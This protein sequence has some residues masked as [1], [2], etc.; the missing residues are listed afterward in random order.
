MNGNITGIGAL[1]ICQRATVTGFTLTTGKTNTY[2]VSRSLDVA[3]F[4]DA[5]GAGYLDAME[6]LYN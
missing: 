2:Y 4:E 6:E 3:T 5:L 1:Y